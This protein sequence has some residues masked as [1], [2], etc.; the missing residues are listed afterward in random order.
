MVTICETEEAI[1]SLQV[2]DDEEEGDGKVP[3]LAHGVSSWSAATRIPSLTSSS[4][5]SEEE[6]DRSH[7]TVD[8]LEA[9]EAQ[10][11]CDDLP[12]TPQPPRKRQPR[13]ARTNTEEMTV[14]VPSLLDKMN[15]ASS[16]VNVLE[17]E[18]GDAVARY[19][20]RVL[21]YEQIYRG[22]R[23]EH[24]EA[25][26]KCKPLCKDPKSL[27]ALRV[28]LGSTAV[29]ALLRCYR[30]LERHQ[31]SLTK[32]HQLMDRLSQKVRTA[33]QRYNTTMNELEVI[34]NEVHQMRKSRR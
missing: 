22:M 1:P 9:L 32:E 16:R 13:A 4:C 11:Q 6:D 19:R 2:A 17:R 12:T 24:G 25:F 8:T 5:S 34:S 21:R 15:E 31:D 28:R 18:A 27:E 23:A 33:K 26:D 14:E 29:E 30:T 3:P 20:R 10:E 7:S